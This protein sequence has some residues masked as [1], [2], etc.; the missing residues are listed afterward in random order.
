M[1]VAGGSR[2]DRLAHVAGPQERVQRH[3]VEQLVDSV[4]GLLLCRRWNS[5]WKSSRV[6]EQLVDVPIGTTVASAGATL[7]GGDTKREVCK[8]WAALPPRRFKSL[9]PCCT[10]SSSSSWP[11]SWCLAFS[12]STELDIAVSPQRLAPTVHTV[13]KTVEIPQCSSLEQL[14]TRPSLCN[15]RCRGWSGQC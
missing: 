8:Y 9:R 3:I 10:S 5:W 15:D 6:A 12:S 7:R 4:P 2:P 11:T 14:W 1:P 13:Q